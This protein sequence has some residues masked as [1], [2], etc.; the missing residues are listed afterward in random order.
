MQNTVT[1]VVP[2]TGKD[3]ANDI[4]Q[5]IVEYLDQQPGINSATLSQHINRLMLVDYSPGGV[6]AQGIATDVDQYFETDG[7]ATCL[8]GR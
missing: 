4:Y 1:T 8:I 6:S 7:P 3:R 5:D 2:D